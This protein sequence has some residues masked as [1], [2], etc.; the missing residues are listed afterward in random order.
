[1]MLD[2]LLPA[3]RGSASA[4][5]TS[6]ALPRVRGFRAAA[7]RVF[8]LLNLAAAIGFTYAVVIP[9]IRDFTG[10]PARSASPE[11]FMK[12]TVSSQ[13]LAHGFQIDLR[14]IPESQQRY[15]TAGDWLWAGNTLHIRISREMADQDIRYGML[16]FV[17]ELVEALLCRAAGISTAQV[18]SFDISHPQAEEPGADP[19][20][21]YHRQHMAAEAVERELARHLKVNWNNYLSR[22]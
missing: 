10:Y 20:A 14:V 3:K 8:L 13:A 2:D 17:H 5:G 19:R 1:M 18:D 22:F 21:P 7:F 6:G 12:D 9:M 16:L 4:E 15:D 11:R